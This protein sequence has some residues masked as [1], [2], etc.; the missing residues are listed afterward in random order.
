MVRVGR[1]ILA[2]V[3]VM[4]LLPTWLVSA[5]GVL[6][7]TL[8]IS[9]LKVRNDAAGYDEFIE[10]Y[11]NT[12]ES[13]ALSDYLLQY[14][15]ASG[16]IDQ[17]PVST[18]SLLAHS[19]V[20]FAKKPSQIPDSI[21]SPFTNLTDGGGALR[22]LDLEGNVVD[23]IGWTSTAGLATSVGITPVVI[24][25]TAT[26]CSGK[27]IQRS[28][29]EDEAYTALDT[30]QLA[31]PTPQSSE[32]LISN[33]LDDP[34]QPDNE[35][36]ED[37]DVTCEGIIFTE[38]LPNPAGSDP[39]HEFIELYNPTADIIGLVGCSLQTSSSTKKYDLPDTTVNPNTYIVLHDSTTGLVLPNAAGGTVWLLSPTEELVTVAYPGDID[40]DAS[41]AFIS[42]VWQV[43]YSPTSGAENIAQPLKPCA[44]GQ[45]RD[46][47]TNRCITPITPAVA[48][49]TSCKP[50]QERNPQTNRCRTIATTVS[51]LVPCK[52]GQARNPETNRCRSVDIDDLEPCSQ[53]QERNPDTNRCR[54][55]T[56]GAQTLAAVK[57]VQ[58]TS[59]SDGSR[60]WFAGGAVLLALG[61][62]IYEWR[63]DI[64]IFVRTKLLRVS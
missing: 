38:L 11:N 12:E 58:S 51:S 21:Q 30:W 2:M 18:S 54:K 28:K 19:S 64:L 27:S 40:D 62:A 61:Y 3:L 16:V 57:D 31:A 48:T 37:T 53:G 10:L 35:D 26:G 63:Q 14:Q 4:Q 8:V 9:E 50:G 22:I 43:S 41:W 20:V 47:T 36:E 55:I 33:V 29:S 42:D 23:E 17:K 60:W 6:P 5:Q 46:V 56:D 15:N 24:A 49:L 44:E 1:A 34:D 45:I 7:P 25:C 39:G 59:A 32:L 13:L 52:A